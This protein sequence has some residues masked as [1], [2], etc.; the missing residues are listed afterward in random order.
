MKS[1]SHI[2]PRIPGSSP[3]VSSAHQIERM[4]GLVLSLMLTGS[5]FPAIGDERLM[6]TFESD[7]PGAVISLNKEYVGKTPL[8]VDMTERVREN[9]QGHGQTNKTGYTLKEPYPEREIEIKVLPPTGKGGCVQIER[10]KT[11]EVIPRRM[12]FNTTLCPIGNSVDVN[13]R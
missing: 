6:T 4:V 10:I 8:S 12:F 1:R 9:W 11:S 13:V 5:S 7:R 3:Q 2:P